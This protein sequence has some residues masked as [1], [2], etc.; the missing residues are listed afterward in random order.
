MVNL[1]H[2]ITRQSCLILQIIWKSRGV[3]IVMV[4]LLYPFATTDLTQGRDPD[5]NTFNSSYTI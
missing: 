3:Y 1:C 5:C 2:T 4:A